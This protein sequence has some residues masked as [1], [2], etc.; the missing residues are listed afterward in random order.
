MMVGRMPSGRASR[1]KVSNGSALLTGIDGRSASARRYRDVLSELTADLGEPATAADR[2]L[3]K[4]AAA[5]V[6]RSED[7]QA[8]IVRG[9]TVDDDVHVRVS[10][11]LARALAAVKR[12]QRHRQPAGP[13]LQRVPRRQS[14]GARGDRSVMTT[15][16]D[17]LDDPHLI[18]PKKSKA[19][20]AA[21]EAG[22]I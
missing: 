5:L 6:M 11:A 12:K 19:N 2:A 17:A 13:S 15:I 4:L 10:N 7:I 14:E 16:L 1:A 18:R 8:S 21:D 3:L 20:G 9:D 22:R